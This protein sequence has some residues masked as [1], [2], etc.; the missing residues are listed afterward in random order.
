MPN[1]IKHLRDVQ[2]DASI[3]GLS[4]DF[5]ISC[6]TL[7]ICQVQ[8]SSGRKTDCQTERFILNKIPKHW[9]EYYLFKYLNKY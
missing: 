3:G 1:F 7:K 4:N 9:Q 5:C 8:E 2:E 6:I